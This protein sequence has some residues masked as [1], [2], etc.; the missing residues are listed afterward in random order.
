MAAGAITLASGMTAPMS[1]CLSQQALQGKLPIL[2]VY[3]DNTG[4]H[5]DSSGLI[6]NNCYFL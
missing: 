2:A 4:S 5:F 1:G 6:C 3:S